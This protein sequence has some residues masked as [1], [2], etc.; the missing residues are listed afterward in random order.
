MVANKFRKMLSDGIPMVGTR[1]W[2]TWP[3]ITEACAA[4]GIFDYIEFVA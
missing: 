2:S 1:I 3:T 4:T